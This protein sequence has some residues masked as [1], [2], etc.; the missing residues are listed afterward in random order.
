MNWEVLTSY[1][2]ILIGVATFLLASSAGI[3]G[4]I[5][6]LKGQSLIGDAIGHAAYPGIIIAFMIT[7]TKNPTYLLLGAL[8]TGFLAFATIQLIYRFSKLELDAALALVLSAFFGF[9]MVLK[10]WIQGHPR[11]QG[12]SQSG[13]SN[14]IFGQ[15]AYIMEQ[16]VH[17]ILFVAIVCLLLFAIFYKEIK[18]F[19]FDETYAKTIGLS[20]SAIYFLVMVM[21]MGIIGVGL[22]LVGTILIASLLI[23]PA[24]TAMQWSDRFLYVL[25]IAGF[26]GGVSA[27]IGTYYST[28]YAGLSTGPMIIV[29]MTLF[30]LVSMVIGPRGLVSKLIKRRRKIHA[31]M[32]T[33]R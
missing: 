21:T 13:L 16:D 15:A 11:Y 28:V 32:G 23:V 7:I 31:N 4:T 14:Y 10:T 30:A 24:I 27:V 20:I 29:V 5:S 9:G 17:M 12:E 1:S 3:I 19:I 25:F 33:N 18:L 2:F 8:F 22:K 6:V 26:V